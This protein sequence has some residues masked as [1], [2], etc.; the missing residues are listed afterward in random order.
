MQQNSPQWLTLRNQKLHAGAIFE[1]SLCLLDF[2]AGWIER[3]QQ[4][5]AERQ[6]DMSTERQNASKQA[7][8]HLRGRISFPRRPTIVLRIFLFSVGVF[9]PRSL[10]TCAQWVA[11]PWVKKDT[12][13]ISVFGVFALY[14][15]ATTK[16]SGVLAKLVKQSKRLVLQIG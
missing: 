10:T 5:R 3:E 12:R 6:T 9:S 2:I 11:L 1:I 16:A 8:C 4:R 7:V 14:N 13:V 15:G